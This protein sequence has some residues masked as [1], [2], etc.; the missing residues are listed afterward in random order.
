MPKSSIDSPTPSSCS[1]SRT[2]RARS[3]SAMI[4]ASVSSSSQRRRRDAVAGEQ[5]ARRRRAGRGRAATRAEMFTATC[6]SSAAVAPRAP[7]WASAPVEHVQRQRAHERRCARRGRRSSPAARGRGR[8]GASARAPR[9]RGPRRSAGRPSAGRR[10]TSSP[11]SIAR[12]R[13]PTSASASGRPGGSRARRPRWPLRAPLAAYIA[14]SARCR[15]VSTS[16]PC[17]GNAAMPS[18]APTSSSASSTRE[19]AL[20]APSRIFSPTSAP[21]SA[22][23]AVGQQHGELV[24]AEA[25]DG[26]ARAQDRGRSAGRSGAAARR[27]GGGRACR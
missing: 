7:T 23:G 18:D 20:A 27:R 3:G 21:A 2:R 26:V 8:G 13:S 19:R 22:S 4:V 10:A 1:A 12:R 9:R 14:T 16:S 6:R 15:S 17:S 24:A 11:S 5:R 25:R